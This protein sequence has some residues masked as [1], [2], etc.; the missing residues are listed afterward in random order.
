MTEE[1]VG[2]VFVGPGGGANGR[3]GVGAST[4]LPGRSGMR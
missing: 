2:T 4:N 1:L 3:G